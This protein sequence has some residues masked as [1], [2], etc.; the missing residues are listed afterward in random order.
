MQNINYPS[1]TVIMTYC[2]HKK[3]IKP[4]FIMS[5]LPTLYCTHIPNPV[6]V[7]I[8][9]LNK[10]IN[11]TDNSFNSCYISMYSMPIKEYWFIEKN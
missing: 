11:P 8:C 9:S 1:P 3:K 10:L 5:E 2:Y 6:I 7:K 4:K